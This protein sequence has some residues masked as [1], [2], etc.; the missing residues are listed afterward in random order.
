MRTWKK[1]NNGTIH[2]VRGASESSL[3]SLARASERRSFGKID[4]IALSADI[5]WSLSGKIIAS[6]CLDANLGSTIF[7]VASLPS[8]AYLGT[9][10]VLTRMQARVVPCC[11]SWT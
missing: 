6:W 5:G 9:V 11:H 7:R 8:E 1:V 3:P 2:D 4:L 10:P